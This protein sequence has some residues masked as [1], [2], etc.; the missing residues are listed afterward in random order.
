MT[1]QTTQNVG[2]C[3]T[4]ADIL[5][6]DR[7]E[8][9]TPK[10]WDAIGRVLALWGMEY[11]A[12]GNNLRYIE[13]LPV[14]FIVWDNGGEIVVRQVNADRYYDI[15]LT[16]WGMALD[17]G[18]IA[19]RIAFAILGEPRNYLTDDGSDLLAHLEG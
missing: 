12:A 10:L 18:T 16:R 6:Y 4:R 14:T 15:P 9:V 11:K 17:A 13:R 7:S 5:R 19:Q 1:N 3:D 8:G 2:T